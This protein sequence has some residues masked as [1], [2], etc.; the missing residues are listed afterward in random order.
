MKGVGETLYHTYTLKINSVCKIEKRH[1]SNYIA[2][3]IF[4]C[5]WLCLNGLGVRT[6]V[7]EREHCSFYDFCPPHNHTL[8]QYAVKLTI[9]R[10]ELPPQKPLQ[11]KSYE[12]PVALL[13]LPAST[14]GLGEPGWC[15]CLKGDK[16]TWKQHHW[17]E[18]IMWWWP[19]S[20]QWCCG[21]GA[22]TAPG[23]TSPL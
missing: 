13:V 11:S 15:C 7:G 2:P 21:S 19:S 1:S 23:C 5:C 4:L 22:R 6:K 12:K 18:G 16:G 10:E 17:E 14:E 20:L 9:R 8:H 3:L